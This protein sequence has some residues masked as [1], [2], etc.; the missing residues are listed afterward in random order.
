MTSNSKLRADRKKQKTQEDETL[1]LQ[2]NRNNMQTYLNPFEQ[3][4][5]HMLTIHKTQYLSSINGSISSILIL[6]NA[7]FPSFII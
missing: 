1:V 6:Y 4:N 3:N 2:M 7:I 5:G